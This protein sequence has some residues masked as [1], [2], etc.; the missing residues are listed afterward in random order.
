MVTSALSYPIITLSI[1]VI[2]LVFM[3]LVVVPI[4]EQVYARMGGELP[5]ITRQIIGMSESAPAVLGIMVLL[6]LSMYGVR[7]MLGS[8]DKYQSI[9][10][11]IVMRLPLVSGLIRKYQV[12][13]FSRIMHLLV[14]SDVPI[15]HALY[16]MRGIITFYPYRQSIEEVCR[17]IEKGQTLTGGMDKYENLYGKRFLVLL[18]VGE[19]TNSIEQMLLTQANDTNAELEHE[20]KQLNNI[21]EPFLILCI[22]IIVAFVLIAMYMPMFKMGMVI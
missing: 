14:S 12:S 16:L 11:G 3:L 6:G 21:V 7:H 4:F 1:A 13:R 18:K 10:S 2:V 9:T 17:M 20:I 8:S 19:E 22:G 5:A 15:L